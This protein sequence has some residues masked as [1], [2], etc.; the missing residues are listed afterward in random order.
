[1][2]AIV[3]AG[4]LGTRLRP[5]ISDIPKPMAPI[6]GRPFLEYIMEYLQY[7]G[8]NR[9]IMSTG[10]KHGVIKSYF[11]NQYKGISIKYSVE[12]EPLGTGGA[13]K[14]ALE[15][16]SDDNVF[17]LNGDTLFCVNFKKLYQSHINMN[18]DLTIALKIL[19]NPDR[20]GIIETLN[21]KIVNFKE[22]TTNRIGT[23]NGGIYII[24][25]ELLKTIQTPEKFSFE[26]DFLEKYVNYFHFNAYNSEDYFIDIGIPKDY[27]IAQKELPKLQ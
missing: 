14:K 3:L 21:N 12:D 16:V 23:I 1:M 18:S 11:R 5:L 19:K 6:D 7:Q 26:R 17:I 20:F 10:Y 4:G 13:I 2:E 27:L 25:T 9:V 22:K 8:I 15:F 24:K